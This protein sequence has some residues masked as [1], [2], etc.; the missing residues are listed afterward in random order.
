MIAII[1]EERSG[2]NAYL[3]KSVTSVDKF[4]VCLESKLDS[5]ATEL[6]FRFILGSGT[7]R[8]KNGIGRLSSHE[9]Y[10]LKFK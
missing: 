9:T 8:C 3:C 1:L 4:F 7:F 6:C 2:S 5:I 10:F